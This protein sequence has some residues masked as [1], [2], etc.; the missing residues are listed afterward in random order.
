MKGDIK[1]MEKT[2]R[3]IKR[4]IEDEFL[5]ILNTYDKDTIIMFL[6]NKYNLKEKQ[7]FNA[8][9]HEE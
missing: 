3:E 8:E 9:F 2:T 5:R 7:K 6:D 1:K 4:E